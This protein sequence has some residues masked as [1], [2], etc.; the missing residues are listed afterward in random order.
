MN[1]GCFRQ[2]GTKLDAIGELASGVRKGI[3]VSLTSFSSHVGKG[4]SAHDV[5]GDLLSRLRMSDVAAG[6]ERSCDT[7]G[8]ERWS[9]IVMEVSVD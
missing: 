7:Q 1:L 5:V 8:V 9:V 3:N 2:R 6:S 4:S